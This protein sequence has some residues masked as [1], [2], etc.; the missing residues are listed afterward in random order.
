MLTIT[1]S[2]ELKGLCLIA[3][4][5]KMRSCK[6]TVTFVISPTGET[7]SIAI[8]NNHQFIV[9]FMPINKM[10]KELREDYL[11]SCQ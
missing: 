2:I 9:P 6:A 7:L 4:K 10:I 8:D 11:R 3:E 5:E 1:E